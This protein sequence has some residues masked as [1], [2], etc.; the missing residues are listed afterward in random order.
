M[1]DHL[2]LH[3]E[4]GKHNSGLWT[5]APD[6]HGLFHVVQREH[7]VLLRQT[8]TV[9]RLGHSHCV[10]TWLQTLAFQEGLNKKSPV[11]KEFVSKGILS[12]PE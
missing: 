1:P 9:C 12:V 4:V 11:F 3:V 8:T 6:M 5:T 10:Y 2:L 7:G